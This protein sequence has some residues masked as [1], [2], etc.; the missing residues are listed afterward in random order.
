MKRIAVI[1]VSM[2]IVTACQT[3]DY[4]GDETSY[5]YRIP[6]GSTL[7]LNQP[8]TIPA[9]RRSIYI[10]RGKVVTYKNVD[11]YYPHCRFKLKT[12][13]NQARTVNPDNFTVTKI[14]DWEDYQAQ[15]PLRFADAGIYTGTGADV[16]SGRVVVGAGSGGGGPS[17]INYA[18]IISLKSD[19][20]PDVQEIVC[21]HWGDRGEFYFNALTIK[22]TRDALGKIF[23]LSLKTQ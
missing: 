16:G 21:S 11:I 15:G 22:E 7:T 20:Q 13:S 8:L 19:S 18:T 17:I 1:V 2:M 14:N 5:R 4:M 9:D 10:F 12:V 23:T 6:V 3:T